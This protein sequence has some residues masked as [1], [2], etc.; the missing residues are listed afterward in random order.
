MLQSALDHYRRQQRITAAGLN[1]ARRNRSN[2]R[3]LVRVVTLYQK[4]GAREGV[5]S[6]EQMLAEQNISA[7]L[8]GVVNTD[9]FAG[10]ASDGRPLGSLFEQADTDAAF[11]MMVITQLRDAGRVAAG[12]AITGRPKVQGYTR[13]INPPSC[14]R[15]VILAGKW[16]GWNTGFARHPHCDCTHVP[17]AESAV[18]LRTDPR[19]AFEAG[20]VRGLSKAETQAI[21]EGSD[22]S[23]VVNARRSQYVDDAG[24][25]MTREATT[26]RGGVAGPRPTPEQIYRS[27]G[28]N[29]DAA[30]R[31]LKKFG[32][33]L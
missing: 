8:V 17:A 12:V 27:A 16:F 5:Q 20:Q 24:H 31:A 30:I 9:R 21:T 14:P 25:R 23:R 1:A 32:Y 22:M 2:L 4:A 33:I 13:M 28:D 18:E 6:V 15:C 29:R 11:T 3:N 19:K 26:R 7:P 10:L